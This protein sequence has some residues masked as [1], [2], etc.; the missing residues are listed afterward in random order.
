MAYLPTYLH[1]YERLLSACMAQ[2][3]IQMPLHPAL[4]PVWCLQ[5]QALLQ[6]SLW[7]PDVP[8][9]LMATLSQLQQQQQQQQQH[10]GR[11]SGGG[12][13]RAGSGKGQGKRL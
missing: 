8:E 1:V 4:Q 12:T 5:G 13:R 3:E 6:S 7:Q 2:R 10:S 11:G 9:S